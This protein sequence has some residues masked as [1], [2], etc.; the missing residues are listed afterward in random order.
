MR[1]VL[2]P[3]DFISLMT[4]TFITLSF[5]GRQSVFG[6]SAGHPDVSASV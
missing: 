3:N 6:M 2:F 1:T 4:D 5:L